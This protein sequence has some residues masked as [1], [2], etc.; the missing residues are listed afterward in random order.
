MADDQ[1][2]PG[3]RI[4]PG[5]PVPPGDRILSLDDVAISYR[6]PSLLRRNRPHDDYVVRGVSLTIGRG[7]SFAIVGESGSGKSTLALAIAGL[8]QPA[9][10]RIMFDGAVLGRD[11]SAAQRRRIQL[12]FQDPYSS[13]NPRMTVRQSI[14][15]VLRVHRMRPAYQIPGRVDE[16]LTLVNLT[17]ELG[18]EY[19]RRLSGGQR[20]RVS[21]A[22][23]LAC[24]PELLIADEA[25]SALDVSVQAAVL[26]LFAD[27]R[28]ELGLT[29]VMISHNLAVVRQV[30]ERV[31]VMY[32]GE[33]VEQGLTRAVLQSPAHDYTRALLA[34]VPSLVPRADRHMQPPE[35]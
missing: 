32:H 29:L 6:R 25:T 33:L 31:A 4:L 11:R 1:K 5:D 17:P 12:I 13:L 24:E 10:G 35:S 3:D 16:L 18:D 15:E 27:L 30:S 23:A 7:E 20:Q 28:A 19:P 22:R 2:Q 21:I 34:S 14:G 9:A 26:N 8:L